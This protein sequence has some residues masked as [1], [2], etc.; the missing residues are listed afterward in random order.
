VTNPA[1]PWRVLIADD[2]AEIRDVVRYGLELDGRFQVVAEAAD[3]ERAIR[4]AADLRPDAVVLDVAMPV[5]SGLEALPLIRK[6]L[7]GEVVAVILSAL[8]R[9]VTAAAADRLD[10]LFVPKLEACVLP[11]RL[12]ALCLAA[13]SGSYL[14]A[15]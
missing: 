2:N 1:A 11:R 7:D 6:A 10:A 15:S 13:K 12:A 5:M 8:D 4:L 14:A 9:G 3:G